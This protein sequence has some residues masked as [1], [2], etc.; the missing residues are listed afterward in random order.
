MS[1]LV[2]LFKSRSKQ[3]SISICGLDLAGKTTI[4]RYLLA[5]EH[6]D[7]IPTMGINKEVIH[8]PKLQINVF[9][10]GGQKQLRTIWSDIND[11][12]DALI[13]VVDGA[14]LE[15][16]EEAREEFN[17]ILDTQINPNIPVLI[18]LNKCDLP[19]YMD[20]IE[21]I[22]KFGLLERQLQWVCYE[23]SALTGEG[24]GEAFSWLIDEFGAG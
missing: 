5:G 13:Y 22:R 11:K 23:T 7:T 8:F 6:K 9:D 18:L 12:S 21:F 24:I 1:F 20:R 10:L 15:R 2:N 17:K 16:L 4:V 19:N 14:D 3:V